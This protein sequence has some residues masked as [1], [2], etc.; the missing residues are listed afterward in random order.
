MG[1]RSDEPLLEDPV[2]QYL[3]E[4][5]NYPLL[6]AEEEV[7]L[8]A[9]MARGREAA[10]SLEPAEAGSAPA[11]LSPATRRRLRRVVTEGEE[12]RRRFIQANLRLVVSIAKRY[13]ALGLP[14]LDLV[15]EGNLGLMRAVEK[16]EHTRGFKFSTYAT[17]WIRQAIGRALADKGRTIRVPV[18]MVEASRRVA[19]VTSLLAGSL[20]R[21]PSVEEIAM[22]AGMDERTV[23][24]VR[25][26]LPD[27]VSLQAP[28]G[29]GEDA[30]LADVLEDRAATVPFDAAAASL[31]QRA[32]RV[33]LARLSD[34]ERHVLGL[35][36]GLADGD[37]RTLEEVGKSFQLTRER[38]R[39]IEA[40]ALSKLRHPSA[41]GAVR[42]PLAVSQV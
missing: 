36:F 4:I 29:E 7:A 12:A 13:Q 8:A 38:I 30:E 39:Q 21:E 6:T 27:P 25:G 17:W 18:H 22:H 9:V 28:V 35:R 23:V 1:G 33:A 16:F 37:P 11:P 2:R 10:A 31:Q 19:K 42:A 3:R 41:A 32:L 40:K 34:R 24:D 20:G 5:G 15:Q 26:V 14:L